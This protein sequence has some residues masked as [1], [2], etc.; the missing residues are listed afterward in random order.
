[1]LNVPTDPNWILESLKFAQGIVGALIGGGL[2]L[3]GG[4]LSDR[5]KQ[6]LDYESRDR[7]EKT[8]LTGM[9]AVRNYIIERL[10][11]YENSGSL[12]GLE[13][14]RTAQSYVHRIID[15]TP[16]QNESVM[17][18]VFDIGIKIDALIATMNRLKNSR[19][20]AKK[21]EMA[22]VIS[23]EVDELY[24]ALEQFDIIATGELPF[25]DEDEL[26]QLMETTN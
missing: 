8:L 23:R 19:A 17:I 11:E 26:A 18:A 4:W 3:V 20:L 7:R 22:T 13:P 9:F 2:V 14:L 5:R 16:N 25:V 15:K 21:D 12:S 24:A 6:R 1:M 10:N